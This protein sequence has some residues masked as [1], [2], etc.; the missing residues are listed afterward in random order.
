MDKKQKIVGIISEI[1]N[2]RLFFPAQKSYEKSLETYI[3]PNKT[4][5]LAVS[6]GPD[7]MFTACLVYNFFLQRK[8][9]LQNLIFIHCNHNVRKE[10]KQ[11]AE[12]LQR[13]FL[14]FK[15]LI[16]TRTSKPCL[17]AGRPARTNEESLRTW[18]YEEF[19]KA[20]KKYGAEA[21]ILGHNLSD[22]IEST[23][24]HMLRGANL[25]GFLS[26][27]EYESHPLLKKCSVYRPLL[28]L[29]KPKI[30]SLC[31]KFGIPFVVDPTNQDATTSLRNKLRNK[32]LLGLYALAHKS[33][34]SENT[35]QQSFENIYAAI[36]SLTKTQEIGF[37]VKKIPTC[38]LWKATRAYEILPINN[39]RTN[40]MVVQ[41]LHEFHLKSNISSALIHEL[42]KFFS[43]AEQGYKYFQGTYFFLAHGRRYIIQAPA[44]FREK[45]I[46]KS[47]EITTVGQVKRYDFTLTI[48]EKK[49]IPASLRFATSSDRYHGKTWNQYCITAKIPIFRR[50]FIP[51]LV[52]HGKIIK[53]WKEFI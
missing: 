50:N 4:Y 23:F 40:E 8:L 38:S 10:N 45:T 13:F 27:S 41:I 42:T 24:L 9:N 52:K 37:Q 12:C 30:L 33:N 31:S 15:L 26:M 46:E 53:I 34:A 28:H 29:S 18:R 22:R 43:T 21:L 47:K 3:Q 36:E 2:V 6:G 7:S 19:Q 11:E 49:F 16:V 1:K 51:V 44:D 14:G 32:V 39:K 48:D 25:K 35:F 17:P 5:L 20:A